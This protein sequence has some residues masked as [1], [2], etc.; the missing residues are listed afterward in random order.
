MRRYQDPIETW[1]QS[2]EINATGL[3]AIARAFLDPMMARGRGTIINI[4]SIQGVVAPD[5]RNYEGTVCPHLR[6]TTFTSTALSA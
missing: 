6:T 3:F 2:M 4:G 1:R 5:F